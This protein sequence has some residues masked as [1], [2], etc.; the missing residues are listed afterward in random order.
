MVLPSLLECSLL[1]PLRR[2]VEF[3][4]GRHS[5]RDWKW[6]DNEL[7]DLFHGRTVAPGLYEGYYQDPDTKKRIHD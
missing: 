2:D 1:I 5:L 6:F 4:G 7:S 3:S